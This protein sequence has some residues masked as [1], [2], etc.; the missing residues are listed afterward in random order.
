[1]TT[2]GHGRLK[3]GELEERKCAYQG[4]E[5]Y[6]ECDKLS[7]K[8][9]HSPRCS[10]LDAA[11][12]TAHQAKIKEAIRI[13][14][15][16]LCPQKTVKGTCGSRLTRDGILVY[17]TRADCDYSFNVKL[18]GSPARRDEPASE[19]AVVVD[20]DPDGDAEADEVADPEE[21]E[22]SQ[23]AEE[24][25]EDDEDGGTEDVD[26]GED[27]GERIL[28]ELH[29]GSGLYSDPTPEVTEKQLVLLLAKLD[30]DTM[31]KVILTAKRLHA[32]IHSLKDLS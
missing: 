14:K 4:C 22:D 15:N 7:P 31:S 19:P 5:S 16:Q 13:C 9:Y 25:D 28:A 18:P 23:E 6:F 30:A 20:A 26:Q 12:K 21:R 32:V 11:D 3:S 27:Q 1:M 17:C 24:S 10:T 29:E 2:D 8:K